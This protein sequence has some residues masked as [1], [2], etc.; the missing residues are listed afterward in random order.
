M[1]E[2]LK[3]METNLQQLKGVWAEMEQERSNKVKQFLNLI[4]NNVCKPFSFFIWLQSSHFQAD[5]AS[6]LSFL[7]SMV[8]GLATNVRTYLNASR[9]DL[10][11][12]G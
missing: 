3:A 10:K 2:K 7:E 8:S 11:K 4:S 9:A 12:V 5:T 6:T 1:L